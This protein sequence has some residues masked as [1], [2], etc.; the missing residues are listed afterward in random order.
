MRFWLVLSCLLAACLGSAQTSS[1]LQAPLSRNEVR[2]LVKVQ[3]HVSS[4]RVAELVLECGIDF[5]P[6][7]DDLRILEKT[8]AKKVVLDAVRSA[9]Q[10]QE[11]QAGG[12]W[13]AGQAA[14][15]GKDLIRPAPIY[16]PEPPYPEMAKRD[17]VLGTVVLW[18]AIDA[19]GRVSDVRQLSDSLGYGFDESAVNTVRTWKF[20]PAT[21]KGVPVPAR[22]MVQTSFRLF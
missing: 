11:A 10:V 20:K 7:A 15:G 16:E 2:S 21:R 13:R 9:K 8:G 17:K 22:V 1:V 3:K 4:K 12:V 18:V 19:Q 14:G 5:A 6:T